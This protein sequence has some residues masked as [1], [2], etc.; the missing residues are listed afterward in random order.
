MRH[1]VDKGSKLG[2]KPDHR[3]LLLRSLA[4]ALILHDK[5]Q[6]TKARAGSLQPVIERMIRNTKKKPN[7][8]EVIRYLESKLLDE[9]ASK[10]MATEL[11]KKYQNQD[12]G[13]T[14]ITALGL[15]PGDRAPKVQIELI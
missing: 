14:R 12:S 5:I 10:K 6:T 11:K 3:A 2:R 15:R 7:D 4:T 8:R 13:F 9:K 1:R